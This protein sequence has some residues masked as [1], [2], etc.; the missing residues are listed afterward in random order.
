M[1]AT[2]DLLRIADML[3][4]SGLGRWPWFTPAPPEMFAQ[5]FAPLIDAQTEQ[6][7]R[8]DTPDAAV[9]RATAV[10]LSMLPKNGV[11]PHG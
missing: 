1:N 11:T 4:D 2:E 8:G 6:L 3:S 10:E 5:F 7:D 9:I